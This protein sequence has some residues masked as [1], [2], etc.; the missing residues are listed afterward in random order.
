[1]SVFHHLGVS[2]AANPA[3]A[4]AA[5]DAAV[6]SAAVEGW[7]E[8]PQVPGSLR[9][10]DGARWTNHQRSD[11]DR[12]LDLKPARK[13]GWWRQS[14]DNPKAVLVSNGVTGAAIPRPVAQLALPAARSEPIMPTLPALPLSQPTL[15][16]N[17][18][19]VWRYR[20]PEADRPFFTATEAELDLSFGDR[21]AVLRPELP[22][23]LRPRDLAIIVACIVGIIIA[24]TIAFDGPEQ[25][26]GPYQ[27]RADIPSSAQISSFGVGDSRADV[28]ASLGEPESE[29]TV[30][31]APNEKQRC[32]YYP[33]SADRGAVA[34]LWTFCFDS[35]GELVA[36]PV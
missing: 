14:D 25:T 23:W 32:L 19:S 6:A 31:I 5:A 20:A 34:G 22:E 4:A 12:E 3:D 36:P 33:R 18:S 9:W 24:L 17:P 26:V 16:A 11:P 8:D 30:E 10:W 21:L 27:M 7:Y 35:D 2:E 15:I 29:N 1:M 13:P 28:V